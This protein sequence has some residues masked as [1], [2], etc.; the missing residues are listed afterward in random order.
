MV[1]RCCLYLCQRSCVHLSTRPFSDIYPLRALLTR[2]PFLLPNLAV[3]LVAFLSLPFVLFVLPE[4]LRLE[5]G[6][7]G[8]DKGAAVENRRWV[9][10]PRVVLKKSKLVGS[11]AWQ[12]IITQLSTAVFSRK[13]LR[14]RQGCIGP[15]DSYVWLWIVYG[16]DGTGAFEGDVCA[17]SPIS[18]ESKRVR[19]P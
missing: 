5:R 15:L 11:L 7:V 1:S 2:Y 16:L 8:N 19:L 9:K 18:N 12:E 3:A 4:T 13:H 17:E 6:G 14:S 10:L